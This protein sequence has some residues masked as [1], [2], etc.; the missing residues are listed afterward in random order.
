MGL[1]RQP[2][3]VQILI[4][5]WKETIDGDFRSTLLRA[6][7][8]SREESAL[9]FLLSLVK[10][11]SR[12]QSASALD[13]LELHAGSPEIQARIVLAKNE[14]SRG[15]TIAIGA[16]ADCPPVSGGQRDRFAISRGVCSQCV[17]L[18][19]GPFGTTL[20]CFALPGSR[21]PAHARRPSR[22]GQTPP[23]SGRGACTSILFPGI[24][25]LV[26]C[27]QPVDESG[28]FECRRP[29]VMVDTFVFGVPR[30]PAQFL[31][32]CNHVSSF[33][34]RDHVVLI[35]MERP[36]RHEDQV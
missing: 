17:I 11:G 1:W 23:D 7:S 29:H 36:D 31:D 19:N 32:R 15:M 3:A 35:S 8:S 10:E 16:A 34:D 22:D 27:K 4:A 24:A 14:R 30:N 33:D 25:L 2:K 9:E 6:I 20:P 13:A 28:F 21:S 26:L 5:A 12:H 18:T